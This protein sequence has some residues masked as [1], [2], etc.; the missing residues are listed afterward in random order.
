[1]AGQ[2]LALAERAG[3]PRVHVVR[4]TLG[5]VH[6]ESGEWD[7]ALAELEQAPAGVGSVSMRLAVH[8][9]IAFIAGHR[10]DLGTA[11]SQLRVV[12]DENL[13]AGAPPGYSVRIRLARSVAAEQD[14]RL[15][16]AAAVLAECLAPGVAERIPG[17]GDLV[18]PLIRLAL[19][20]GD[21][22]TA[23]RAARLAA[24]DAEREPEPYKAAMADHCRGLVDGDPVPVLSAADYFLA[25]GRPFFRAQ[26]LE[27]AA[28]LEAGRG[29]LAAARRYLGEAL[30]IYMALGAAWDIERAGARLRPFG[31]RAVRA[32]RARPATGWEALTPTEVKVAYLVADG[33]SNPDVAAALSL[34]RNTVQTHV[35]HILAKLG[36]RSRAEIIR[37]A[38]LHPV[39][40]YPATA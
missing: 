13:T 22:E 11:A 21:R 30:G 23:A 3:T 27:D 1:M 14:G 15:A 12:D 25:S 9:T 17:I 31:V 16:E 8:G 37:E 7:D 4:S 33:R 5:D 18:T 39:A 10:G 19:A 32:V 35:S 34:S 2:A 6:F 36:V 40:R 24:A 20:S 38:V 26:A 28:A 29:E